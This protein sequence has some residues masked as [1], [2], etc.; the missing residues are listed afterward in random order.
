MEAVGIQHMQKM[1][2]DGQRSYT[3]TRSDAHTGPEQEPPSPG[4]RE[5]HTSHLKCL[6]GDRI[7]L[8]PHL[9]LSSKGERRRAG[10]K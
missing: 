6:R 5:K 2:T 7:M 1:D 10:A 3:H 8:V 4:Q 9:L